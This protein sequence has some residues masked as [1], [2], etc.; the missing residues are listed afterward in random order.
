VDLGLQ[1]N[2]PP[3]P[4]IPGRRTPVFIPVIFKS[5]STT[6]F[7]LLRGLPIFLVASIVAAEICFGILWFCILSTCPYHLILEDFINFTISAPCKIYFISLFVLILQLSPSFNYLKLLI[8][9]ID[10]E[11]LKKEIGE[12]ARDVRK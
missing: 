9:K 5:S 8:I 12:I 2:L 7:H 10:S 6:S 3:F 11:I 1:H 4:T